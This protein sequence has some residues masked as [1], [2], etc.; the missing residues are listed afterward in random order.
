MLKS[1][2]LVAYPVRAYCA[3]EQIFSVL[4]VVG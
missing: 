2:V 1:I 4:V 3:A